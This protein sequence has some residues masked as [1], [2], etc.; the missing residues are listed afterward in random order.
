MKTCKKCGGQCNDF[1]V[2]CEFCGSDLREQNNAAEPGTEEVR[3]TA[4]ETSSSEFNLAKGEEE[5]REIRK[6]KMVGIVKSPHFLA[7]CIAELLM[8]ISGILVNLNATPG[9]IVSIPLVTIA[10]CLC[11]FM[12]CILTRQSGNIPAGWLKALR[13]VIGILH[14]MMWVCFGIIAAVMIISMFLPQSVFEDAWNRILSEID[15]SQ[16]PYSENINE[17]LDAVLASIKVI[18]VLV[19][20]AG[21]AITALYAVFYGKLKKFFVCA[22]KETA[23]DLPGAYPAGVVGFCWFFAIISI[24]GFCFFLLAPPYNV[25]YLISY[26]AEAAAGVLSA[27]V[28]SKVV[29]E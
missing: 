4:T 12:I 9:S 22:E 27:V 6:S 3:D 11:L 2:F 25:L 14:V 29:N 24:I 7:L 8:L 28:V 10:V 17:I 19:G 16:I 23:G 13:I 18:I 26:A 5:F 15:L 21:M 20:I 1:A